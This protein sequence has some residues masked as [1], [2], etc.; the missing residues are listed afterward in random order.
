MPMRLPLLCRYADA[1]LHVSYDAHM[2]TMTRVYNSV[3]LYVRVNVYVTIYV[4]H[5]SI[6]YWS[7]LTI[8]Y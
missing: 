3:W 8:D 4:C 1:A 7:L 2:V 5:L 6:V